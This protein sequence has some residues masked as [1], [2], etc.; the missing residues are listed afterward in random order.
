MPTRGYWHPGLSWVGLVPPILIYRIYVP[1]IENTVCVTITCYWHTGLSL[2][3]HI[4]VPHCLSQYE[5][6]QTNSQPILKY[7][8]ANLS[9]AYVRISFKCSICSGGKV[10]FTFNFKTLVSIATSFNH[11]SNIFSATYLPT[12]NSNWN[13]VLDFW[14]TPSP[15]LLSP[16]PTPT[17]TR[18]VWG[19][20][21]PRPSV[22]NGK[23][24]PG[25]AKDLQRIT[26]LIAM[27]P[28]SPGAARAGQ[29]T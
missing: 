20:H 19:F 5:S 3:H 17:P 10:I 26:Q 9:F 29:T 23:W 16:P 1:Q 25:P 22:S 12:L 6:Q 4:L 13:K 14:R 18:P 7:H 21:A 27:A 24:C 28:S 11:E 8:L 2:E 15:L